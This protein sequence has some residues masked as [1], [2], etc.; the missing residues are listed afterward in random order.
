MTRGYRRVGMLHATTILAVRR[1]EKAA[2]GGDGQVTL[3]D[4]ILKSDAR[5]MR[6]LYHDEVL[7]GFAG[8]TADAFALLERFDAK[9]EEFQGN[10]LRATHEL[11]KDWRTDRILRRLESLMVVMNAERMLLISGHGEVI[12]PSDN[13]I[14]IGSGG[15]YATAAAR[16][17]IKHSDLSVKEIVEEALRIA[18]AVCIYTNDSIHVEEL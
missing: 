16:A 18:A 8:A 1:D 12:E 4:R 2:M 5:K 15:A 13:I 10:V 14:G 17:L 3:D 9:L 7:V 11:A 6:R